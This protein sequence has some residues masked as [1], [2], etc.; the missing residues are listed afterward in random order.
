M[1]MR[2]HKPPLTS[3]LCLPQ[4]SLERGWALLHPDH[5]PPSRAH[6]RT[7]H[8]PPPLLLLCRHGNSSS[9]ATPQ[10]L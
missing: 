8:Q 4:Q 7:P 9:S 10:A 6:H 5:V 2:K 1:A 3:F